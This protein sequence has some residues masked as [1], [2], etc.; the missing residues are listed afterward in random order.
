MLQELSNDFSLEELNNEFLQGDVEAGIYHQKLYRI[1]FRTDVGILYYRQDL[2]EQG[3]F[4]PPET[5][6]QLKQISQILQ[7]QQ[8]VRWGY[9][10]QGRH[11]EALTA[12][13]MEVLKGYGGFWIEDER[14][15][16]ALPEA[17]EAVA[18][19]RNTIVEKISPPDITSH[20]EQR[21][22]YLFREGQAAFMR[23]WHNVWVDIHGAESN[24]SGKI[25]IKPMVHA[26]GK[27]SASCRGGWG[28]AIA[29][30]AKHDKE[31][32]QAIKF[33]TSAA[34]QRQFTLVYGSVP[35]RRNLLLEP[36]IVAK[37][38]HYPELLK[39][40]D[41]YSVI[42]PRLPQY[43][44]ASCILQKHLSAAL[45]PDAKGY[46]SPQQAMTAAAAETRQLLTTGTSN[47]NSIAAKK[48]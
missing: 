1:P 33:F 25:A 43:A 36:T 42:R 27:R 37:Y 35:S 15:G 9:L 7:A 12:M 3:K 2:L 30:G 40:I 21:T 32:I 28:F 5:F 19:L 26:P 16:L 13:F 20:E 11:G 6:E 47:C 44:Q 22:R 34:L 39:A 29:K 14:V 10:W 8:K 31:A 4:S 46:P 38:S 41:N 48:P 18:F 24:V 23:N 17:I 45:N